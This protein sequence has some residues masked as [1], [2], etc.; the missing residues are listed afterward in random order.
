VA[1]LLFRHRQHAGLRGQD[2]PIVIGDYIARRA[3]PVAVEGRADLAAIGEGDRGRPIPWLHQRR[4][5]FIKCATLRIHQR[6]PGPRLGD[7]HHHRMG[8]RIAAADDQQFKCVVDARGIGLPG[9]DQRHHLGQIGPEQRRGHRLAPRM[10]PIDVA[11]DGVD[12]AVV[13]QETVGVG[14][15]PRREGVGRKPLMH[16]RQ[17]RDRQR[18][19][20]IPVEAADLRRE[21]KALID[22][23]A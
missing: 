1:D 2:H 3:Q 9:A 22:K 19:A 12:L 7:Q 15:P 5:V 16:E 10:H 23:G 13:A 21:Q 4:V 11:P 8:Q 20:Q 18:V 6:V 14:E 17:R